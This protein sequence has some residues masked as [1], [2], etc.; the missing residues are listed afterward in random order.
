[1]ECVPSSEYQS[2]PELCTKRSNDGSEILVVRKS[3]DSEI[4]TDSEL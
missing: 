4:S 2:L 1:M 3:Q